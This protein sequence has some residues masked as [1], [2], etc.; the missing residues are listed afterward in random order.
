MRQI[1]ERVVAILSAKDG[2]VRSLGEGVYAGDFP[3]P[4]EAGGF[5]FGQEN[6]R[7][8]LDTGQTA[9]GCE[10]WWGTPERA[11]REFP[12]SEWEWVP[13]DIDEHRTAQAAL[14]GKGDKP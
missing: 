3:L 8:D 12:D 6:P 7:L 9:W 14:A 11:Y 2:V 1:G 4:P 5:N 10:C 13:V